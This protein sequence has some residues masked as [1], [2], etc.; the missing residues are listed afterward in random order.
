M[1][2]HVHNPRT[3]PPEVHFGLPKNTKAMGGGHWCV[4]PKTMSAP[5]E[6]LALCPLLPPPSSMIK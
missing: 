3:H 5:V 4:F 2:K 6:L 1:T